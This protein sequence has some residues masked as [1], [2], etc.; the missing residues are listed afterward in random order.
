MECARRRARESDERA[1]ENRREF[2][3]AA[4]SFRTKLSRELKR[5][6]TARDLDLEQLRRDYDA[7]LVVRSENASKLTDKVQAELLQRVNP[8]ATKG[9]PSFLPLYRGMKLLIS[10]KDCV[11]LGIVKGCPCILE[12]IAFA[13]DENLPYEHVAGHPHPLTLMPLS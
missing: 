5:E 2:A 7:D 6:L 1:E 12:E 8:D 9:L 4:A 10:S 11:R 3:S 13:D